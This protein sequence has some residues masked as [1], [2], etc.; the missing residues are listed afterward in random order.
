M[1]R[2]G[3]ALFGAMAVIWGI[4][5]L[6]IKIAIGEL[7]PAS[8]VL[9]RTALGAT[10]LLPVAAARGWLAPLLPYW[11]WVLA[12]TVVEVSLPWFL[13]A[14]GERRLS[15][16]L[17]GLMIAAVPLIAAV[18]QLL[19]RA[20]ERMD[21]RRMTGLLIGFVGVAVL[22]GLNVS[23][24]DLVAVGEVGLVAVG[25]AAGPIIIARRLPSL[26]AL[27]V[28]AASLV[29]TALFY[30]PLAI[31]QLPRSIPSGKVLLAVLTLGVVCTALAF[32]LFFALIGEVGPVRAT[33]I[34]YFNP[35][36]ALLLGVAV[37]HEP[38]TLGAVVG[39]SLILVGSVLA[40]RRTTALAGSAPVRSS[41]SW[42]VAARYRR[43][44]RRRSQG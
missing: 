41:S 2:R 28:V 27:G 7:T 25:Y 12:Y 33:V 14:D 44:R 20:D 37:L 18:I 30:A 34:T 42:G 32:L 22:V 9:L 1:T 17:T 21:R 40:T 29:L 11:R 16:S 19:T 38:F 6:L 8:L 10:L 23:F 35:A 4:P 43:V 39:F 31:P 13:L 26:P 5:Y 15:S 36:V 24:K 3:W